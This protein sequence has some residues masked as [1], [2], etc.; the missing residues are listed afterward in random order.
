MAQQRLF[1]NAPE[2][3]ELYRVHLKSETWKLKRKEVEK[4]SEGRCEGYF[5]SKRCANK[6]VDVHHENYTTLGNEELRHLKHYCRS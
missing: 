3:T 1:P 2:L 5:G 4:R 6:A